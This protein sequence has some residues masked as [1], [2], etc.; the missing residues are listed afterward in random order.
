MISRPA[1]VLSCVSLLLQAG[2]SPAAGPDGTEPILV[3][4]SPSREGRAI[5]DHSGTGPYPGDW[6]RS[7]QIL[8]ENGFN[9]ILPN[10]LWAGQAHYASDVLPRS[11][12]FHRWGDQ[13]DQC[14]K[15]AKKYG[16]QVHV[17]KVNFNL[18]PSPK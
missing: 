5:W 1:A 13:I 15:A 8:P 9:M 11:A 2:P 10:M 12:T 4:S 7:A 14:V 6:D 17:W 18:G 3:A 16:L